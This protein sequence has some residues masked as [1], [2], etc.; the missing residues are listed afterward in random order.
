MKFEKPED[1]NRGD[2]KRFEL[3]P[4]RFADD[5]E[6]PELN[7]FWRVSGP[8]HRYVFTKEPVTGQTSLQISVAPGDCKEG[9]VWSREAAQR[10]FE[11]VVSGDPEAGSYVPHG[12]QRKDTYMR[13][14]ADWLTERFEIKERPE[15]FVL[16]GTEVWYGVSFLVPENFV[17][18]KN[19]LVIAQWREE[20][21]HDASPAMAFRYIGG[22]LSFTVSAIDAVRASPRKTAFDGPEL[23]KGAWHR[24]MVRY[25][26]GR[27]NP[28]DV[29]SRMQ[30][31]LECDA[32]V[33]GGRFA[34]YNGPLNLITQGGK[35][36]LPQLR[37]RMGLYRNQVPRTDTLYFSK[38]RRGDSKEF[39][40]K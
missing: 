14:T 27:L 10:R 12:A 20:G 5:F 34:S 11:S 1:P 16:P 26:I 17:V 32:F 24:L 2:A 39:C 36:D 30:A 29:R 37:F 38:F 28:V 8:E 21:T 9:K 4:L 3:E 23:E 15:H 35:G 33:D 22:K 31:T 25:K 6:G 18:G 13:G 40:E 7:A 19:R